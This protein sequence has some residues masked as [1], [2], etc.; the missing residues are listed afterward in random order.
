M[1]VVLAKSSRKELLVKKL[2]VLVVVAVFAFA[3]CD[4]QDAG[5]VEAEQFFTQCPTKSEKP[6]K[7]KKGTI[8]IECAN[9]KRANK[10]KV[11]C[12]IPT[13]KCKNQENE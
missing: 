4:N 3:G 10:D 1:H 11:I 12:V 8:T 9:N 6:K 7:K 13:E 2:A 5:K